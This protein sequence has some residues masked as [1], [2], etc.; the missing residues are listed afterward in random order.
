MSYSQVQDIHEVAA[1]KLA[2]DGPQ[3]K[4]K[5]L[6]P[7]ELQGALL[8]TEN[9]S[10]KIDGRAILTGVKINV[11]PGCRV[12]VVGANGAGKTTLMRLLNGE[13]WPDSKSSRHRKLKISYVTQTHLQDLESCLN[14]TCV[15]YFRSCLPAPEPGNSADLTN[16]ASDQ[17]LIAYLA[18]FGLGPQ[19]RQKVGTLSGGQ[20]ARLTFASKVWFRP[21]LLLLDEPTNHLDMDTLDALADALKEFAGAVIIVSHNQHFL[22]NVCNE[23]WV[24]ADGKVTSSGRREENFSS[25]FNAYRRATLKKVKCVA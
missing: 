15:D 1:D 9:A 3:V 18:N 21:H 8:E 10:F 25:K 24:V 22:K 14:E 6:E 19:S 17:T 16:R 5:L 23:L 13:Q 7:E 20:K 4:I 12:A 11:Q 2:A